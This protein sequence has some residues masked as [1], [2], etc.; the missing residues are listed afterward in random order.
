[1][2]TAGELRALP[3][4]PRALL[5]E[6]PTPAYA[7]ALAAELRRRR[8]RGELGVIDEIVGGEVTVLVDGVDDPAGLAVRVRSWVVPAGADGDGPLV[9]VPVRYDG[10]DLTEIARRWGVS[11]PAA[12]RLHTAVDYR[13]AFC[14][15]APGF[16][17]LTGLPQRLHLPRRDTPRTRVPAGAVALAGAYAGI[18]PRSSPGG[19]QLIGRT[20][21]LLFDAGREA[22]ALLTPGT[23]V[24]FVE[25]PA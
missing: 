16:A 14:G 23:R 17:Y 7:R 6:T 22:P 21:L 25:V 4:G 3:A 5:L 19:W 8:D 1:M 10:A 18:Y 2:N 12:V 24:R 9:E 15:F 20:E 13:V 11:E